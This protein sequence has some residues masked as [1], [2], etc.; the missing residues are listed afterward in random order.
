MVLEPN[1]SEFLA[2]RNWDC[3]CTPCLHKY[4]HLEQQAQK[5]RA[6]GQ[7]QKLMEGTHYEIANGFW[8]FTELHHYL[9]GD[10]CG[11]RC[12]NCVYGYENVQ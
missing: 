7:A 10:C 2:A 12:K 11:N 9:R 8:V 6:K 3:V 4:N 5:V 1:V